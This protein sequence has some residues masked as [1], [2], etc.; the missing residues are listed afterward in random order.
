MAGGV[1]VVPT[2]STALLQ[3]TIGRKQ[4]QERVPAALCVS[5]S[6]VLG[7]VDRVQ[8]TLLLPGHCCFRV[9]GSGSCSKRSTTLPIKIL[10]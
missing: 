6:Q 1:P 4:S 7:S 5:I 8:L 3:D 9:L 10:I 2:L